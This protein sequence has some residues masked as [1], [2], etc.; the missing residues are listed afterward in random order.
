L[1]KIAR[2]NEPFMGGDIRRKASRVKSPGMDK[3]AACG[4]LPLGIHVFAQPMA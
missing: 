2:A 3:I 1:E 4:L